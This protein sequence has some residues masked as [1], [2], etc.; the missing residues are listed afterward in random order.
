MPK[1][2]N[3]C[4]TKSNKCSILETLCKAVEPD[5]VKQKELFDTLM[6]EECQTNG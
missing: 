1:N 2:C 6:D 4:T 3:D 5:K